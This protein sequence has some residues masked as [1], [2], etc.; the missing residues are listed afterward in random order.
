MSQSFVG[1]VNVQVDR[2]VGVIAVNFI[3]PDSQ[4]R[5]KHASNKWQ[6]CG[7]KYAPL[8]CFYLNKTPVS[9]G[10][11]EHFCSNLRANARVLS[12]FKSYNT[13]KKFPMP[14]S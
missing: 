2:L 12:I 6:I 3:V 10:V 1:D 13:A 11:S 4:I 5:V 7:A 9:A 14:L 8:F